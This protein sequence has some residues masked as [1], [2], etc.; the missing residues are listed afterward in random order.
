MLTDDLAALGLRPGDTVM[1]HAS[2]RAVGGRAEAV[3]QA[4]LDLLGP[5]GT[6]MVYV[7]FE[8]TE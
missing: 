7:D 8:P 2:M 6:L 3:V 1:V 4:L 5:D